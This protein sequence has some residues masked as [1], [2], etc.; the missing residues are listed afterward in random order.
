MSG[1]KLSPREIFLTTIQFPNEEK[2]KKRPALV[3]SNTFTNQNSDSVIVLPITTNPNPGPYMIP[4]KNTDYETGPLQYPSQVI[5]DNIFTVEVANYVKTLGRLT[6][7]FFYNIMD[8]LIKKVLE[9]R[10]NT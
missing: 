2:T 4:I 1:T 10:R 3:I 7:P 9:T 5:I 8:E 6:K